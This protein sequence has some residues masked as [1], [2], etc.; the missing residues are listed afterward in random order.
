MALVYEKIY[1]SESIKNINLKQY[2]KSLIEHI[3]KTHVKDISF[4]LD[5]EPEL[6]FDLE[7]MNPLGLILNEAVM[8]SLKHG[9]VGRSA[10]EIAIEV[11][12][13]QQSQR[14]QVVYKDCSSKVIMSYFSKVIMSYF[15]YID[16][17][18]QHGGKSHNEHKRTKESRNNSKGYQ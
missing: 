14:I 3:K 7:I 12:Y 13:I 8:N 11:K 17:G 16:I 5:I 18:G 4:V 10:G 9:F 1:Q 2:I 6:E 15:R